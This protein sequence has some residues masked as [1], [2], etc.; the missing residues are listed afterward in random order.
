MSISTIFIYRPIATTLLAIGLG[1]SGIVAFNIL[2]VASLPQIDFPTIN[3]TASLP[4]ASP[5]IMAT[6]VA[7]PIERQLGQIAGI[8][9][10]TSVSN[11]GNT[12]ITVQFDLSRNIDGA[13]RDVQAAINAAASQLPP[14]LPSQPT[15]RKINPSD[16][17]V[18]ILALTSKTASQ[19][20]MYDVA[21]TI[22]QQKL[23]Q[24]DSVGQVLVGGSSLPAVRVELNPTTLNQ[25]GISL[26]E[27]RLAIAT[28]NVNFP[29]GQL[30]EGTQT[31][32][33]TAN[34]QMFKAKEY[35]P[36]IITYRNQAPVRLTDVG[37]IID[38]VQDVR[39][40]GSSNGKPSVLLV[41]FKQPG[42]NVINTVENIYK[43]MPQL[44]AV[45]PADIEMDVVLDRTLTIRASLHDVEFTLVIAM[46]LVV[47]S[48][49]LFLRNKRAAIIA[50]I[51][52]P[53]SLL[54]TFGF[55]YLMHYSLDNLSL[56]ALTIAT[57]FVIDDAVVVIENIMRH[58]ETGLK[59]F[60]AA[61]IGAKEVGFTVLSMSLSLIAVF[62]PILFMGGIVGR[63]IQEFAVTLSIAVLVSL[64]VSLTV[65]PMMCSYLLRPIEINSQSSLKPYWIDPIKEK[66]RISLL[67]ALNRPR[68]ML[69]ITFTTMIISIFLYI[70]VPKGFFPQ[71]DTGRIMGTIQAQQ[72]IS[73]QAMNEKFEALIKI[74]GEDPGVASVV[75]I[76]GGTN[77]TTNSGN[78]Y[79]SLKPLAE[80]KISS[81]GIVNRLRSKLAVVPA[82][83]LYLQSAQDLSVGGRQ[84]GAQFQY[85]ISTF[86]LDDLA[87]W[88]PRVMDRLGK[89]PGIVD[90]N[91]DQLDNGLQAFVHI[92]R[93]TASRF[94]I[95]ASVIDN[96]LYDAF[97]QRLV[98]LMYTTRNQYYVVMEV[99]PQYWQ[100]PETLNE[101]Y[102]PASNGE[103][104]P[105]ASIAHFDASN[106]L[107][108]VNHQGLFPT[109]TF[110]FNLLP[111]VA[112][113]DVVDSINNTI[114]EM[115]LPAG[116]V[117]SS[118]QGTAQAFQAS[119]ASEPYLILMALIAVYIVLGI[120]YE[121]TI[122]PLT[123]LS[124]LPSAGVGALL[125][126]IITGTELSIIA[127]IGIILLIGIV[128]KNAIMMIDFALIRERELHKSS[129]DA[130]FEACL[131]RF[132]PIM[133][134]TM[135][136][137]FS[138]FPLAFGHGVGSELRRPLGIAIIGGLLLSQ[139]LTL[140][141]TPVIYLEFEK[142]K[143]FCQA[144]WV[145]FRQHPSLE[146]VENA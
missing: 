146:G 31:A 33:I 133:M 121:S 19:G 73:F 79:I 9:E 70:F 91:N 29:K 126:L 12:R 105:L 114:E 20:E 53:L 80:R 17:P 113:G 137:L 66:Y 127:L 18:L 104:V 97:G 110:S 15:Y 48:I 143:D 107:L 141:T 49:Y 41:V 74:V 45:I 102:I 55:M 28:G 44:K 54:G 23:S 56:M 24:I 136:A 30:S 72:N 71:Q 5:V 59:P 68:L 84:T 111:G 11:L 43:I 122:H 42:A 37:E 13:A 109:T 82:A 76:L 35:E 40:A 140:Y 26:E 75:G 106:T 10:M 116:K 139:M 92:D 129:F 142:F 21:S 132:R 69:L 62:I 131:I 46:I 134:T 98:S 8:T 96:T 58:I 64:M 99:A 118:F 138:A 87:H 57:G 27:V 112:L 88:S 78:V 117:T 61:L 145:R 94:G 125:A 119:L 83:T 77:N 4:G 16:P 36:L 85:A 7:T 39:N 108:S 128:K 47:L 86:N 115:H 1:L 60:Q 22:L 90:L 25:Y 2:P 50:S 14:D 144:R 100:R 51:A 63:L 52:V 120:L 101:I 93:D 123:I 67:W 65:T 89:V 135:A 81:D 34:D 32:K 6:S 95:T 38:S 103:P 124:T 130:I 3:V